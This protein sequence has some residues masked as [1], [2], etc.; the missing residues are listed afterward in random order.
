ML[1]QMAVSYREPYHAVQVLKGHSLGFQPGPY[2]SISPASFPERM[3]N[4]ILSEWRTEPVLA[5]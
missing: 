3:Y 1:S 2:E 5:C 4:A